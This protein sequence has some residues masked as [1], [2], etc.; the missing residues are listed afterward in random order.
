MPWISIDCVDSACATSTRNRQKETRTIV[1]E[2]LYEH[3]TNNKQQKEGET[4]GRQKKTN[5][6]NTTQQRRATATDAHLHKQTKNFYPRVG[7]EQSSVF[8]RVQIF[9]QN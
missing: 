2:P 9:K 4:H 7:K 8:T 6:K 5:K 3:M 1:T